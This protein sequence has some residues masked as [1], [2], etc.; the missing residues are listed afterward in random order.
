[1]RDPDKIRKHNETVKKNWELLKEGKLEMN[2]SLMKHVLKFTS[3]KRAM[4][5]QPGKCIL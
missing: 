2:E 1:M 5:P 3:R 4:L